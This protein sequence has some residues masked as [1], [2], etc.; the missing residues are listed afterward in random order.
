[1]NAPRFSNYDE[2][3]TYLYHQLPMYS[4]IGS[5]ALR[6]GLDNIIALCAYLGN[7][8][9]E[10]KSIHIAGSNGKGSVSHLLSGTF[11]LAG[12][13]TGLYTS[14]H[15]VDLRERFRINGALIHKEWIVDFLNKH[16]N[17]ITQLS[18]SY[19]E[20]NVAMAFKVFAEEG[21]DIAIIE[22]G[23]GGRLDSTNIIL[24]E[25]SVITNISLEHAQILGNTLQ[26][27]A[28]EKAGIIKSNV[29]VVI[30]ETQD[31][32]DSVFFAK[33][34]QEQAP[35]TFADSLWH[36]AKIKADAIS[37]TFKLIKN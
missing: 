28:G 25:L 27:I 6:P 13:K 19:F 35:I 10:F 17:F 31:T 7:P 8:Q 24:P 2:A 1:M 22:T 12:Y 36:I 30:G 5:A 9:K 26:E 23:L 16:I 4:K 11:Q 21:V 37:Q 20:L 3:V 34:V 33:A 15:L 29:P 18:P 14:P 32:T